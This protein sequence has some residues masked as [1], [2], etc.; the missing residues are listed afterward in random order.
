M[1]KEL[2]DFHRFYDS[3][4]S[5]DFKREGTPY[6]W[7]QWKGT[8]P[9]ID[10]YCVCSHHG[11]LDA[12]F[13]FYYYKCPICSRKYALGQNIKLIELNKEQISQIEEQIDYKEP[14]LSDVIE[15]SNDR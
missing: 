13:F 9:C 15:E 3:I 12:S 1:H 10:L 4:Y 5:Q 11:H 8:Q 2:E 14:F 7:I 6:G